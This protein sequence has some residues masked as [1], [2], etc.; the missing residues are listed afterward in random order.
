MYFRNL[1][2]YYGDQ[3]ACV[4]FL[5]TNASFVKNDNIE[6]RNTLV[7]CVTVPSSYILI[8]QNLHTF[9]VGNCPYYILPHW[10]Q[11]KSKVATYLAQLNGSKAPSAPTST[12]MYRVRKTW[13]DSKSQI[14]AY[15]NLENAKK[16]CKS[17]YTVFD[18]NGN[19]VY[20]NGGASKPT[21]APNITY[22]VYANNGILR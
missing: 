21:T 17:G 8:R 15:S 10:A 14:G 5:K 22:C 18:N 6:K 13:A 12:Q 1:K 11:F 20:T 7:S 19:A 16:A 9:V 4:N 2:K 3:P